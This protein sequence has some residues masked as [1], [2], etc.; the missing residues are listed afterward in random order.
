MARLRSL[1]SLIRQG[2]TAARVPN[3]ALAVLFTVVVSGPTAA[4][5][6]AVPTYSVGDEVCVQWSVDWRWYEAQ[7]TEVES[8]R[9]KVHYPEWGSAW[10]E[11]VTPDTV[12][13]RYTP[14]VSGKEWVEWKLGYYTATVMAE[15]SG[16]YQIHYEGYDSSWDEWVKPCRIF[17]LPKVDDPVWVKWRMDWYYA[18]VLEAGTNNWKIHYV[19]Y[20]SSWDEYVDP[21]RIMVCTA[22][23]AEKAESSGSSSQAAPVPSGKN[24][25][26][27]T[28]ASTPVVDNDASKAKPVGVGQVSSGGNSLTL[29]IS[30]PSYA[31]AV[32][33]YF[34]YSYGTGSEIYLLGTDGQ[35]HP[36]SSGIVPMAANTTGPVT[37]TLVQNMSV[38]GFPQGT[39]SLYVLASPTG[40]LADFNFW[41]TNFTLSDNGI[42]TGQPLLDTTAL[43]NL[44]TPFISNM[45][46]KGGTSWYAQVEQYI[47]DYK[48]ADGVA[49]PAEA[50]YV[51]MWAAYLENNVYPFCWAALKA[52]EAEP[53]NAWV[54]NSA[55]VCLLELGELDTAGRVLDYAHYQDATLSLTHENAAVYFDKKGNTARAAQ[56]KLN[57]L[58]GEPSWAHDAWDGYHYAL[59][60]GLSSTAAF[61]SRLPSNYSLLKSNGTMGRGPA[62]TLVCCSCNGG[63]YDNVVTCV[64][65]CTVSLA[66]FTSICTPRLQCCGQKTPFG[67]ETGLC[68]PPTG[69]QVCIEAN[70]AGN[71]TIK[72]GA[73]LGGIFGTYVGASTNF[74]GNYNVGLSFSGSTGA[75]A[76]ISLLSS[77]PNTRMGAAKFVWN[78]SGSIGGGIGFGANLEASS[79]PKSPICELN[80]PGTP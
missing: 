79:W 58:D 39:Y 52:V 47:A 74:S 14:T 76:Q 77:D 16:Q 50:R 80:P 42:F 38:E 18:K 55:A 9:V 48:N 68:F 61:D 31:S 24:S 15:S 60:N 20:N 23:Q 65:E 34:G 72:L 49:D 33:V 36:V 35:F 46:T 53:A 67:L 1:F 21:S 64:D 70:N 3:A 19:G 10:D 69:L 66:C 7:V 29:A 28:A 8:D 44:L 17:P 71:Y 40:S 45:V 6:A 54:L 22:A 30:L 4:A 11:W 73:K 62:K 32:D 59:R 51:F 13:P 2:K 57:A 56:E 63:F 27:Y 75:K 5:Y 12:N 78:P 43:N 41:Y 26:S 25:Y 37:S